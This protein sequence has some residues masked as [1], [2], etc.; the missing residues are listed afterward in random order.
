ML[1]D[2]DSLGHAHSADA[3]TAVPCSNCDPNGWSLLV[4][5][6]LPTSYCLAKDAP[7]LS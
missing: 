7:P 2:R 5:K 3:G 4:G 1:D 6:I